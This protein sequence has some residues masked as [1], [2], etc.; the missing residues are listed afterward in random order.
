MAG[1]SPRGAPHGAS[2]RAVVESARR[3]E[4]YGPADGRGIDHAALLRDLKASGRGKA[5]GGGAGRFH[6][7][8]PVRG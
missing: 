1:D 7:R 8:L 2:G 3:A 6:E 4:T 5:P